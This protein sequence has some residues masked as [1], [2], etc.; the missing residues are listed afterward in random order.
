MYSEDIKRVT[1]ENVNFRQVLHTGVH[2]QVVAMSLNE[3]EDIGEEVHE[4]VDQIIVIVDG[5]GKAVVN[6]ETRAIEEHDIIFVPAGA[7]H[8]IINTD[9]ASLK[10]FTVYAPPEHQD[11]TIHRTKEE[12]LHEDEL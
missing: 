9:N 7:R 2:S 3:G 12:A 1:K 4:N 6:G 5:E 11:G 8:N 10:L